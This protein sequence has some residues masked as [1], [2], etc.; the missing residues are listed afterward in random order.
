MLDT[1]LSERQTTFTKNL[2]KTFRPK[3]FCHILGLNKR[4]LLSTEKKLQTRPIQTS[5]IIA[6]FET[7]IFRLPESSKA[8][9]R[10][11]V[12]N[13]LKNSKPGTTRNISKKQLTAIMNLKQDPSLTIVP[14]A[15]KGRSVAVMNT[16]DYKSKINTVK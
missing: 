12:V 9:I 3:T 14:A 2:I 1:D 16:S 13:I 4:Q 5:S 15:D 8:A 11:S 7:G 6:N 10:A